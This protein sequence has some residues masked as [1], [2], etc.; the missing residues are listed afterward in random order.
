MS[1]LTKKWVQAAVQK[2]HEADLFRQVYDAA[3]LTMLRQW[4]DAPIPS[5]EIQRM[6]TRAR[7]IAEQARRSFH[8]T[9]IPGVGAP[10]LHRRAA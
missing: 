3:L 7:D 6:C 9:A 8:R 5:I 10:L 1:S 4:D 2:Q